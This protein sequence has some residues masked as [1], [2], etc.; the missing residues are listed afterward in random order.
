MGLLNYT[1]TVAVDKTLAEMQRVL[2][3][4]GARSILTNYDGEGNPTALSFLI[5]TAAGDRGF[6]L[7][8]DTEAT[9][10][11][12]T[13]QWQKGKVP[14]RFVT[15][16]QSA[17]VSWRILKDWLEAQLAIVETEMVAFDQVMLP[18]LVMDD[19]RTLYETMKSRQFALPAPREAP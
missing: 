1:T 18:Y 9:W 4:A 19:E 15:R 14:R 17:R 2:A 6:R 3:R 5:A 16:E 11:V 7:P 13:R 10:R 12:L 8:A